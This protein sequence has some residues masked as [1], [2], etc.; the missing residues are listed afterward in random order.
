MEGVS[1]QDIIEKTDSV[2]PEHLNSKISEI[3]VIHAFKYVQNNK[4]LIRKFCKEHGI[5]EDTVWS[6]Y[7]LYRKSAK[8]SE[9]GKGTL[10][11]GHKLVKGC[12]HDCGLC[13]IHKSH[14][15]LAN[16]VITNRCDL[17]CWYCFF[18]AEKAGYI[19][20]PS[21]DQIRWMAQNVK[22]E[23]PIGGNAIQITGGEPTL[24][25]DL[26]E[27]IK[28]C[29]EVGIGHIQLNSN[30]IS[31][32]RNPELAKR[33]REAGVNTVY[34][35]F[36]GVPPRSNPKNHWEVPRMLEAC[37]GASLGIV[38]VPTVINNVND[39]EIGDMLRFAAEHIDIIRGVNYQPVSLVGRMPKQDRDKY[40]I[41]IP[42]TMMRLEE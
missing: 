42:D 7:D 39:H 33:V 24:R 26:D 29:K 6:D 4:V 31:I 20:E 14:S 5:F 15:A 11:P 3:K 41:T 13:A 9:D 23:K 40:R 22:N 28:I 17:T 12:P 37:R 21:L 38:L 16:M 34:M 19:Y 1:T 35:S 27:I 36:D 2:C 10:N 32:A 30:A 25:E 18:Y 8:F